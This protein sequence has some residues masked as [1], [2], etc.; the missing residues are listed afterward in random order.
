MAIDLKDRST[1]NTCVLCGKLVHPYQETSAQPLADGIACVSCQFGRVSP[2][3][4][5]NG[6]PSHLVTN[7]N[8]EG[9]LVTTIVADK[10]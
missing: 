1:W 6:I 8:R 7:R 5:N 3:R 10:V 2:T 9:K 4:R